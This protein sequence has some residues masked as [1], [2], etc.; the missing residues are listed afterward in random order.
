L[1]S[2]DEKGGFA[3]S[4][5]GRHTV[6]R[7]LQTPQVDVLKGCAVVDLPAKGS[8]KLSVGD[9]GLLARLDD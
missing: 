2:I 6:C 3:L 5:T 7:L 1:V 9:T 4:V 8:L